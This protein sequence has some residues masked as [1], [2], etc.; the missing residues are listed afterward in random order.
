MGEYSVIADEPRRHFG[1]LRLGIPALL[2]T[3]HGRK[4][5]RLVDLSQGGALILLPQE[6]PV[7]DCILRWLGFE[8]FCSTAWQRGTQIGLMFERELTI[9]MM[10]STREHAPAVLARE[11]AETAAAAQ[12]WAEGWLHQGAER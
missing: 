12:G 9:A 2:E 3:L 6:F 1:R 11:E 10:M 7:R 5:V 4:H 8:L